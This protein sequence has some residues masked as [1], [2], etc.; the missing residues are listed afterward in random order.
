MIGIE[1]IKKYWILIYWVFI[2]NIRKGISG[3][4]TEDKNNII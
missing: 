1:D 4:I 3:T 2:N